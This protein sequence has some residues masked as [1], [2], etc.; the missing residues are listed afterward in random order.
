[1]GTECLVIYAAELVSSSGS[2]EK[3]T[4]RTSA[5][6]FELVLSA[7]GASVSVGRNVWHHESTNTLGA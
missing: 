6:K 5:V 1:M 2:G 4:T 7:C 3:S